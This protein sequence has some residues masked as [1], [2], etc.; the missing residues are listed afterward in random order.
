[1]FPSRIMVWSAV[2]VLSVL[3][4]LSMVPAAAWNG[5][6]DEP[7]LY[8]ACVGPALE[9]AGFSDIR[10][11]PAE[12]RQ[13]INCLAHYGITYGTH[14]GSFSSD[15]PVLRS[16]MALFLVRAAGPAGIDVPRPTGRAAAGFTDVEGL[17]DETRDAINQLL[18]MGIAVG[19]THSAFAPHDTVTRRQMVLFL[20]RFLDLAPVGPGGVDVDDVFPDDTHFEDLGDVPIRVYD[21][22]RTLFEMGVVEGTSNSTFSPDRPLTRAQMALLISRMLGHT[23]ARPAGVTIQTDGIVVDA[24]ADAEVVISARDRWHRPLVDAL[25]DV[26]E[27][28]EPYSR[29]TDLFDS[30]GRCEETEVRALLGADPCEIDQSDETTD[31][32]GNLVYELFVDEDLTLWA[33][34]GDLRDRFDVDSTEYVSIEFT[35]VPPPDAFKVTDDM[36]PHALQMPYGRSVTFT[37]QLV[38]ED[39]KQVRREDEQIEITTEERSGGRLARRQTRSHYTD[40][41]GRVTLRYRI[42]RPR[43]GDRDGDSLLDVIVLESSGLDVIDETTVG[44]LD[45]DVSLVWSSE[46]DEATTLV[47]TQTVS[48]H[49]AVTSGSGGRNRVFATLLDQYGDPVRGELIHFKS[50]DDEGLGTDASDPNMAKEAFRKTTNSRGEATV[51]YFRDSAEPDIELIDALV[52][53]IPGVTVETTEHYW[54]RPAPAGE[55]T[56]ELKH[57]DARRNTLVI[58]PDTGGPYVI[59]YDSEDQFN[60][61]TDT[62]NYATF[63]EEVMEGNTLTVVVS[64]HRASDT[65]RFTRNPF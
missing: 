30:R 11:Y 50:G 20:Y 10:T 41:A 16:H 37:F 8:S 54:V 24:S 44:V 15:A 12:T 61:G 3:L 53:D 60:N 48:Y 56:G 6:A 31:A 23:N 51:A 34:S 18:Q 47:L 13:A 33:W 64:G 62:E 27:S 17:S 57:H 55:T 36:R 14:A 42:D 26:F 65:N 63:R 49:T 28:A 9:D 19:K 5:E 43:Y 25:V 7:A 39:G 1:M 52:E 2:A 59:T 40:S 58:K 32:D 21:M 4:G 35:V 38:D 29:S 45:T 46:D 22:V